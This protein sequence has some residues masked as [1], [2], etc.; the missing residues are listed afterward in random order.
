[1]TP[2]REDRIRQRAYEIW[3]RDGELSGRDEENWSKAV[4]EIDDEDRHTHRTE[5]QSVKRRPLDETGKAPDLSDRD[6][7]LRAA[8]AAARRHGFDLAE[9]LH[10]RTPRTGIRSRKRQP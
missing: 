6:K 8:E 7:A 2:S 10:T 4:R 3:R 9:L 1:M 5:V